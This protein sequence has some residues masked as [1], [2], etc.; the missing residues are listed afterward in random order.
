MH[1]KIILNAPPSKSVSHRAL[2]AAGLAG[3]TSN[4]ENVLISDD[5]LRTRDCL[6][7]L[8]AKFSGDDAAP[9]VNGLGGRIQAPYLDPVK[10]DVGESG[11]TCRL[12]AAIVSAGRGCFE[13]FGAGR[14]HER[15]IRSLGDSLEGQGVRFKYLGRDGCPP[16]RIESFG[17]PG[18][19]VTVALDESSQYLSGVLMAA[20][21]AGSSLVINIGGK[22]VVSWP[23]VHLTLQAMQRF[24]NP[25]QLQTLQEGQWR[26]TD[27]DRVQRVEPGRIRFLV[28]P[29]VLTPVRYRVEGDFSNASYLLAAGAVGERPVEV[30]GLDIYSRQGDRRILEILKSMGAKVQ[31]SDQGVV[32]SPADLHG[33]DLDMGTCPD[34]VPTVAVVASMATGT[35]RISN[36]AHL[37]IKESDR[38]AG[39]QQEVSRAGCRCRL[40]DDGL[41]I[42]PANLARGDRVNFCTYGDHRMAMSLSLYELAGVR[43]VLDN[44]A[45]VNK[46]FPGFWDE[47]DKVRRAYGISGQ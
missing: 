27:P 4:L 46:S 16:V 20:T 22:K 10:L 2:L 14:M 6:A 31:S 1:N 24:G 18:G 28:H 47:W 45:C 30:T 5:I 13:I 38:L 21:M 12:I 43:A 33:V 32:V 9:V 11:T 7:A 8:G 19:V 23:Y 29:G 34:L 42:E 36:V 39:V 26:I 37:R 15:P 44:P 3:G 25:A 41:V 35:T 17:L 40:N